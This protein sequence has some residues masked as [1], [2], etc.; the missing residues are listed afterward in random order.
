MN[1]MFFSITLKLDHEQIYAHQNKESDM[2]NINELKRRGAQNAAMYERVF[3]SPD[4][5]KVLDD[6]CV[7][8]NGTTLKK[9]EGVIDPHASIAAAGC[10]EVLLY[11]DLMRKHHATAERDS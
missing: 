7:R 4:G 8:F 11:I 3:S 2:S 6:L 10:R 1:F 5:K 9:N